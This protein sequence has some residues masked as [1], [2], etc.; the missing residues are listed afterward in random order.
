MSG[1]EVRRVGVLD[2]AK[3]GRLK[4]VSAAEMLEL[5]YRQVKGIWKRYQQAGTGCDL[6]VGTGAGD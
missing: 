2:G 1:E 6:P 4:L 5:G 3:A